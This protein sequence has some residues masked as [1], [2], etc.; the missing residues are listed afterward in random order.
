MTQE[1]LDLVERAWQAFKSGG[2]EAT[3]PMF[4]DDMRWYTFPEAIGAAVYEGHEGQIELLREMDEMVDGFE[5]ERVELRDAGD[6]V[7][8]LAEMRGTI[9]GSNTP[10]SQ[11][12]GVTYGDFRDGKVGEVRTHQTWSEALEAAGLES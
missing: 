5:F 10:I 1:N 6:R 8:M 12:I 3:F 9:R 11:R 2:V 7:V 4:A